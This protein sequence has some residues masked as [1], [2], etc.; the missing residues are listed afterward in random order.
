[1]DSAIAVESVP[2]ASASLIAVRG[3][4]G[5]ERK[6]GGRVGERE[7][8]MAMERGGGTLIQQTYIY[9][10]IYVFIHMCSS[11]LTLSISLPIS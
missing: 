6:K 3:G 5:G 8:E 7:R 1:V 9:L 10:G 4:R 11:F 2:L